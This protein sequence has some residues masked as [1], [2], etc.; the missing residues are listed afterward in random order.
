MLVVGFESE[1]TSVNES[2]GSFELCV[3][4]F[5]EAVL[6]PT[7][8]TFSFSLDLVSVPGTAGK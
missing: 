5:T 2:V 7:Y 1:F 6:L 8:T 4:I 3:R